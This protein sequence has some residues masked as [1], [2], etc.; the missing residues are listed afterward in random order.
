MEFIQDV[1]FLEVRFEVKISDFGFAKSVSPT[2]MY[3][4]NTICGTPANMAP[5]LFLSQNT[6]YTERVDIWSLG[7][8][9]YEMVVGCPPFYDR[10][11]DA[12][13]KKLRIGKYEF[14][15]KYDLSAECIHLISR[16]M[17]YNEQ[18]RVTAA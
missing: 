16:C 15:N 9:F 2:E 5:D 4:K 12:F 11:K 8:I 14:S 7:T 18:D 10:T 1:N 3:R 17:Q 13:T 6:N